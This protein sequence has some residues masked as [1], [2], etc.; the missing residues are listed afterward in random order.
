MTPGAQVAAAIEILTAI[1]AGARPADDSAADY[2]RRR[3]Y[4]GAKDRAQ[5]SSHVYNV[6]R[7]RSSLDWWVC[8]KDVPIG[9]RSRILACL[10]L[11]ENWPPERITG[12]VDGSRFCPPPLGQA[13]ERLVRSLAG[14]SLCHPEMPGRRPA[15]YRS[16]S[17]PISSA[18]SARVWDAKWQR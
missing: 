6:L 5:I 4:I 15:M 8:R 13:E 16:G 9:P 3:R 10:V 7:H 14:H 2:F 17:S 1:D 11:I 12:Y 18:C